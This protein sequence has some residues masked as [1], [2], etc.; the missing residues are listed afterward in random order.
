MSVSATIRARPL[1]FLFGLAAVSIAALFLLVPPIPQPQ[2]YHSFA[3]Q[4]TLL[5]IPNF[6]NVV[7]NLPF[8]LVGALGLARVRVN[9]SASIFFIGVLLTGFGSSFY[10]WN[11]NDIG[12]FWDRLPM[13][14]AF[15]SALAYVIGERLDE[16]AGRLL[17][18]PLVGLGIASLLIWL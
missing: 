17:L 7:S 13:S 4:R 8:V 16:R 1:A 11:P 9:L 12:L 3:D 2:S 15:M 10:H 14:V 18:W 5:G 6:W